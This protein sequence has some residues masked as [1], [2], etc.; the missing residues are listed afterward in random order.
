MKQKLLTCVVISLLLSGGPTVLAD[1]QLDKI[2]QQLNQVKK[3]LKEAERLGNKARSEM[4]QI[5][6]QKSEYADQIQ[7]I[8]SD[9]DTSS[10][11]LLQL[12]NR[13]KEVEENLKYTTGLLEQA[14]ERVST[15]EALLNNRIRLLYMNGV[16]SYLD[17]LLSST[18]FMDFL[19][20][21]SAIQSIV[22]QDKQLLALNII[23]RQEVENKKK[24]VE[25]QLS[26]VNDLVVQTSEIRK[27]LEGKQKNKQ[28]AIASLETK[29]EQ[30]EEIREEHEKEILQ[31][32]DQQG[33]LV[34]QQ[35]ELKNQQK[36]PKK[37][38]VKYSGGQ[39]TWPVPSS[40]RITSM[41]GPRIHPITGKKKNHNGL[42]I[43]APN[44]DSI[45]AAASGTVVLAQWYGDFGNCVIIEHENGIRTLY[46]HIRTGGIKVKVG[47]E[48]S[49]GDKIAEVGSTGASTG[50]HLHFGVYVNNQNVDPLSYLK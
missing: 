20:R 42:D 14:E 5:Q 21:V 4:E 10:R 2:D 15:R 28:V 26:Y 11:K 47:D 34:K 24:D 9:I 33:K 6:K 49:A 29:E 1:T 30:L 46:A 23:D 41:W 8:Q 19:D 22:K 37:K 45:V 48:V 36:K 13:V 31:L 44:G 35:A 12:S 50:N 32:A 7:Q 3:Q 16:V 27:Q 39:M 43:A 18:S 38:I 25:A 40:D 17:V